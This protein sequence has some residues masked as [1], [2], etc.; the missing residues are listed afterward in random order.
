MQSFALV[1]QAAYKLLSLNINGNTNYILSDCRHISDR[2][3]RLYGTDWRVS[4]KP[5]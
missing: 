2:L 3:R 1:K 5:L 4:W